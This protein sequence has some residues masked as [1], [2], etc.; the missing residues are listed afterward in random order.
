MIAALSRPEAY[1]HPVE[2]I[3]VCQTHISVVFLAGPF[4]YKIK[5]PVNLGFLDFSTLEKRKHFCEEE[6]R[7]NRRLAP[8]IYLGVVP[9]SVSEPEAQ[10]RG[11]TLTLACGSGSPRGHVVEWAV[12][13]KRLPS[14]ATLECRL[15]R[16]E[17]TPDQLTL[18]AERLVNFHRHA[19][20]SDR[21]SSFGQFAVVAHNA[22]ENFAQ[23]QPL[24]GAT[25]SPIVFER[26]KGLTEEHLN[27]HHVLIEARAERGV[28]RDTHGDL[29]L[30]HVYLFPEEMPPNDLV[31]I[32]CIEFADRFR[33]ADPVADVAFLAM[34]LI[35]HGRRD[36]ARLLVD[37]YIYLIGDA[38]GRQ[39]LPFYS[40][41]RAVIRAKVKGMELNEIEIDE[42]ERADASIRARA[43]W[44]IALGELEVPA[45]RPALVLIAGLP[46]TGKSTLAKSLASSANFQVL[47]SDVVRKEIAASEKGS[48]YSNTW[49]EQTYAELQRRAEG[50]LWRGERVVVDANFRDDA[51]RRRFLN[52]GR[53][54]GVPVIFI[55]CETAPDVL[56]E[57]LAKRSGD[58]SDADWR[59]YRELE[60]TWQPLSAEVQRVAFSVDT[61][62]GVAEYEKRVRD[63]LIEEGL[64]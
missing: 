46:G 42:A 49:T 53:V 31:M 22:R 39:L 32:D 47:R 35:F 41:Y 10:A 14:D 63:K 33:Y 62:A 52:A 27:R 5:K 34:D 30:D 55:Q 11:S 57:R 60:S 25:V 2:A 3:E 19:D 54:W 50:L 48:I 9:V 23:A 38:E 26:M 20:A 1:P 43:H 40:A 13:M 64:L 15:E 28:P 45:K 24:V 21:I 56:R 61:T 6:I 59:I 58:A 44:L 29:H 4:A 51:M 36:L 12:Q 37:R 8:D 7:L 16:N 17:V 18:L